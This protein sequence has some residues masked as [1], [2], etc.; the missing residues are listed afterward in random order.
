[1]EF[2]ELTRTENP[3]TGALEISLS[4]GADVVRE[5]LAEFY[6][7]VA[8]HHGLGLDVPWDEVDAVAGEKTGQESYREVRRD[9]VVNRVASAALHELG[10]TPALT[11]RIHVLDYPEADAGF[12]FELSVVERPALALSSYEPVEVDPYEERV[13]DEMVASRIAGLLESRAA[14]EEAEP[15][16]VRLGDCIAVNIMTVSEGKAVPHLTGSKMYFEL[17]PGAM[18]DEFV[19]G[20]VGMAVGA[21]KVIDYCVPRAHGMSDDDVDE[22]SATV[23]VL[24]QQVKKVPKLTDEWVDANVEKASSVEELFAGVRESMEAEMS[25]LNRDTLARLANIELEKRLTGKIPDEF[26]QASSA[27]LRAKLER[28]LAEKGQTIDDYLE[29]E[30]MN[31]EELSVQMLIKSGEN[32]RQGFALEALFDGRGMQLAESDLRFSCE[33]AF[34]PGS[35]DEPEL[36]RTGRYALVESAAKRM[37]ALNWL[38]DTATVRS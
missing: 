23:T 21:T 20:V 31:E 29:A 5:Q 34:G 1:M 19:N 8:P 30:R 7:V 37:R 25:I 11:P 16:P 18:P 9:F 24:S 28:E 4:V 17:E 12:S 32:L 14:Y 3:A 26:Y 36:R 27:G 13:T 6:E 2:K 10:I 22:F 15:H 38:A 33:Q 35:F